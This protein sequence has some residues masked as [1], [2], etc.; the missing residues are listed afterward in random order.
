MSGQNRLT[1]YYLPRVVSCVRLPQA[2]TQRIV[3][4][5]CPTNI[6]HRPKLICLGDSFVRNE[7]R[8]SDKYDGTELGSRLPCKQDYD[9]EQRSKKHG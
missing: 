9:R 4:G 5:C 1:E 8:R 6:Q 2:E 7:R 3:Y